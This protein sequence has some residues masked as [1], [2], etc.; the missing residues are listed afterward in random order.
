MSLIFYESLIALS[1]QIA[2]SLVND[3]EVIAI[4]ESISGL[5]PSSQT[6]APR[7]LKFFTVSSLSSL[8]E[9]SLDIFFLLLVISLVFVVEISI[10]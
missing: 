3:D 7:Y 6:I 5:E 8:T 2:F 4:L 1:F 9:M 10:P